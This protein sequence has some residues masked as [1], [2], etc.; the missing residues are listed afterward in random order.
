[1]MKKSIF[2]PLLIC[3]ILL[4]GCSNASGTYNRINLNPSLMGEETHL[5]KTTIEG[6]VSNYTASQLS[7]QFGISQ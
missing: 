5:L 7:A 1:M 2:A 3:V 6:T 4:T